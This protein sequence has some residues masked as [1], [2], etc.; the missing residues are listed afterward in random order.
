MRYYIGLG[1]QFMIAVFNKMPSSCVRCLHS[2]CHGCGTSIK[3]N[4]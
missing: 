1:M 3:W 2:S 4:V